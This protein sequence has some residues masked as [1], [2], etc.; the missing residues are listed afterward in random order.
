MFI[1]VVFSPKRKDE[2]IKELDQIIEDVNLNKEEAYKFID[3][4]F[5]VG[6]MPILDLTISKVLLSVLLFSETGEK[7]RKSGFL[8]WRNLL[9]FL[10]GFEI[11][12]RAI[13]SGYFFCFG[14]NL[15]VLS[16]L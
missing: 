10:I 11:L 6:Y 16:G 13:C 5:R 7:T 8:Y 15:F 1:G 12:L 9:S 3:N 2:K 14:G 4:V